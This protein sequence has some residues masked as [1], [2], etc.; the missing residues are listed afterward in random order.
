MKKTAEQLVAEANAE[1][2]TVT[3]EEALAMQQ[4]GEAVKVVQVDAKVGRVFATYRWGNK[5]KE[6]A[7]AFGEVRPR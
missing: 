2:V 1:I 3:P 6:K 7:F 5:V 4:A